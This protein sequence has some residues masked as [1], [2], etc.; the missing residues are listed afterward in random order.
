M[1]ATIW[2]PAGPPVSSGSGVRRRRHLVIVPPETAVRATPGPLQI[3]RRGRVCV[4]VVLI[5]VAVAISRLAAIPSAGS[6]DASRIVTVPAGQTLSEI[7]ASEMPGVPLD[8]GVVAIRL[9]NRLDS[10]QVHAGQRLVIPVR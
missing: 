4:V 9:A 3:T 6:A 10:A 5:L 1:S 2:E 8:N 7:A